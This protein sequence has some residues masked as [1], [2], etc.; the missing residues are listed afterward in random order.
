[1]VDSFMDGCYC[2]RLLTKKFSIA[3]ASSSGVEATLVPADVL[4]PEPLRYRGASL[5]IMISV[6]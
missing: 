6:W 3:F 4:F 1:V 5:S 2:F